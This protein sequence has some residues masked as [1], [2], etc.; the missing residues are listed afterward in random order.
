MSTRL[1]P[2]GQVIARRETA[3]SE[4]TKVEQA[5]VV[6]EVQ[7]R[8]IV[9]QQCPRDVPGALA[10]MREACSMTALASRAFYSFSRAGGTVAGPSIHLA[11]ELARVWGN[12]DYGITE[13]SRDDNARTSEVMAWAWD[14][15][16][17]TRSSNTFVVPH[18][19]DT[20]SGRKDI[21][22]LR[23]VYENNTNQGSRRVREAIFAV[24]PTWFVQ[25]AQDLCHSTT[26]KG[27]GTPLA[28]RIT[29]AIDKLNELGVTVDRIERKVGRK[30]AAWDAHDVARLGVSFASIRQ[31][32]VRIEDEFPSAPTQ[33]EDFAPAHLPPLPTDEELA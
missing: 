31:G 33:A 32:T 14:M 23:D 27:D 18:A 28:Q 25:E 6:A 13:L 12:I 15:Q 9:A 17:N 21:L 3:A 8:I 10:A 20:K 19:R 29:L 24:I 11:R 5:R 7:A 2:I 30:S 26:V 22:D 4:A 16:T 1:D